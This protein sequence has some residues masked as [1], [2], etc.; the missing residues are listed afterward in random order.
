MR[1]GF[2]RIH[3]VTLLLNSNCTKSD[4]FLF[5]CIFNK[6]PEEFFYF[7]DNPNASS[8]MSALLLFKLSHL[9]LD[10]VHSHCHYTA[11]KT[12]TPI[13]VLKFTISAALKLFSIY[14]LKEIKLSN[15]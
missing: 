5:V 7:R 2:A 8:K 6:I 13:S 14:L 4:N 15:C 3:K 1:N 10:I 9:I 12:L 11:E